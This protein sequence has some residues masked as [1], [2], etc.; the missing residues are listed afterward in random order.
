MARG[1]AGV[2]MG[3]DLYR[4]MK[5]G[6]YEILTQLTSGGMAELFLGY[7]AG[8]GGFR[9]YVVVKRILPDAKD[10]DQFVKMFLDEARITAAFNHPNIGQVFDLGEDGAG[11]YLAMEFIAGQNLN[12]VTGA[13]A[14]K[15]AVLPIGLSASV[16]HDLALAL[17][18]AHTFR[19]PAGKSFP[20]IHRDVAQKNV[21]LTYGGVVKLLDFGIAKARGS[22]GRTN[23]GTVKGTTGYMSP[24]Q[25][26][27]EELD[28]RSDVF[29]LGV[30]LWEMTTGR[31]LFSADTEIDE[32]KQILSAPIGRPSELVPV[33]P[34]TLSDIT[35][36]ALS[37]E[38]ADRFP[39]AKDLARAMQLACPELL[40]DQDQRATFMAEMFEEKVAA[41]QALLESA[42]GEME[43]SAVLNAVSLLRDDA[44]A[45][46]PEVNPKPSAPKG[47]KR[48][49]PVAPARRRATHGEL[50]A[51]VAEQAVAIALLT[52]P[53]AP[54]R[55]PKTNPDTVSP[56]AEA[57]NHSRGNLVLL[58]IAV[59]T[60]LG[61]FAVYKFIWSAEERGGEG[62]VYAGDVPVPGIGDATPIKP[63]PGFGGGPAAPEDPK[64][65]TP[66]APPKATPE[67][68][69]RAAPKGPTGSVT[70]AIFPEATVS[71][72]RTVL[73]KT[74]LFNLSLPAGT[75]LL[76]VVGEDKVKR[77]LSV[78]VQAG[79]NTPLRFTLTDLPPAK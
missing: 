6:K 21:M 29:S 47:R 11:L 54:A 65:A 37:R 27:G 78:Q 62:P 9:K 23:V 18:Y 12:Q 67:A 64:A 61:G 33:I 66:P 5:I 2:P 26:R 52:G 24:E 77:S 41:T 35:L 13:C 57:E 7:T 51:K 8:P 36:R 28:G 20:V 25:V 4:G 1:N 46:F 75:H 42:G 74:P 30:V 19:D 69:V 44:G 56:P 31:R 34:E 79:K 60:A 15:R 53:D 72:G 3:E 16:V 40:F 38:R 32:M 45:S 50:E 59:L 55:V 39:T 49:A 48:A 43:K 58:M 14:K 22:L 68:P 10:N 71:R 63:P 70:L 17:H 73:G 76:T